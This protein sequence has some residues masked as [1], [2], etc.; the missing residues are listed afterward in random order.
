M[1]ALVLVVV[2]HHVGDGYNPY[3]FG[4]L[5]TKFQTVFLA[6]RSR[7]RSYEVRALRFEYF[8]PGGLQPGGQ[9]VPLGSHVRDQGVVII[10]SK[11]QTYCDRVL[12]GS[13][14]N[15]R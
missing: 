13:S 10:V 8:E 15:K 1:F 11:A 14:A 7:V 6:N 12:E 4:K 9:V 5:P 3:L 2:K